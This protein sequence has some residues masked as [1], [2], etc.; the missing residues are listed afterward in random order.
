M[1]DEGLEP[2]HVFGGKNADRARG[3]AESDA[4]AEA[5]DGDKILDDAGLAAIVEA[6][7]MLSADA[8]RA[9]LEFVDRELG[10]DAVEAVATDR[11]T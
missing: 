6:W 3:D 10:S 5:M 1:G 4:S 9:V 8:R 7:P 2:P 11:G